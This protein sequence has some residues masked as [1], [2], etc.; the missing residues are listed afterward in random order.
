MKAALCAAGRTMGLMISW[1]RPIQED[2]GVADY[3]AGRR[4]IQIAENGFDQ[5][6]RCIRVGR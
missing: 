3:D 6:R 4:V 1:L 2:H 5:V